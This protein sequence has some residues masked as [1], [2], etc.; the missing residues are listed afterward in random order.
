MPSIRPTC[1]RA[2]RRL[3]T[4]LFVA[5]LAVS[6]L[7]NR[8]PAG[9]AAG[10]KS[11]AA[12][13]G[14]RSG[15]APAPAAERE[16]VNKLYGQMPLQ[17]E[18][19][20]GQADARFDFLSRGDDY[21]VLLSPTEAVLSLKSEETLHGSEPSARS[22]T[23]KLVGAKHTPTAVREEEL[24]GCVNYFVGRNP[25]RRL[26]HVPTYSRV[27]Y[28]GIY[29]G[30]DVVYYGRRRALEYDFAVAPRAEVAAINLEFGGADRVEVAP[31][32]DLLISAGAGE[33]RMR[34][35]S[36]Y[37]ESGGRRL[38]VAG[39][40]VLTGE[41]TVGFKVGAYDHDRPLVIDPV[42]G[43]STFLGG[44]N[45]DSGN[46]IQVDAAGNAYI[47]GSTTSPDFPVTPNAA[48][49]SFN[50]GSNFEVFVTKLNPSGTAPV[51][52]TYLGG[53][54]FDAATGLA[55]DADGNVYV[56]GVT[57]SNDF[58]PTPGAVQRTL[59]HQDAFV[60]KLSAAGDAIIYSTYLGG[61]GVEERASIAVAAARDIY[62]A[63]YTYSTDFPVTTNA[64]RTTANPY[65][66]QDFLNA[67]DGFVAK[68]HP[69]G[70]GAADLVY[71]T[72]LG[73]NLGDTL[74][75]L[76]LDAA[77]FLYVVGATQSTNFPTT[78]DAVQPNPSQS[79]N[80]TARDN[81]SDGFVVKMDLRASGAA[82]LVYS[83]YV[84]GRGNDGCN[85]IAL[86]KGGEIYVAGTTRSPDFPTSR[87]ALQSS[88]SGGSD[89][90][91]MKLNLARSGP[92]AL[93]YSTYLGGEADDAAAGI[94]VDRAGNAYLTG[95]TRSTSLPVTVG[96][97][98]PSIGGVSDVFSAPGGDAFV[99]KL[100]AAGTALVYFSYLGGSGG[101]SGSAV[102]LDQKG[103]AYLT[104]L[105]FSTNFPL[106][107]N[108]FRPA[109]GGSFDAFV[110]RVDNPSSFAA[111]SA[112][113]PPSAA[114]ALA[115]APLSA[116]PNPVDDAQKFVRQQYLDFLN[117]EP[118]AAGLAFWTDGITS[119]GSD[120][121][122]V[123]VKRVNVSAAFFLSI[124]FQETGYLVERFYRASF[125]RAP[126]LTEF[127]PDTRAIRE[128]V[129]VN[130][131][132]WDQQLE[133]NKRSFAD[134]WVRRADFRTQ[135]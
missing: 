40:Y 73:G 105:T 94:A 59:N 118:D 125:A 45:G 132:G 127:A 98:Q 3:L 10:G 2:S 128:G 113:S 6:V 109:H 103:N 61:G 134:S 20:Q 79:T 28:K 129:I 130:Q 95:S 24:P 56:A 7:P 85:A 36:L 115:P 30:V 34:Q 120:A 112:A 16:R 67:T 19:N 117:R 51:F 65:A 22:L 32:G 15:V 99:A 135:E 92:A 76:A 39:G 131:P 33:V 27:G 77:G 74:N 37:Q 78:A 13:D 110:A 35:P 121:D 25:A 12:S 49:K 17:F 41:R 23:M 100:N 108:A 66:G 91:V 82:G 133:S 93:T 48:Q 87:D 44:V 53:G 5:S 83:T 46:G 8:M 69:A 50:S 64:Y 72:Y 97:F 126:R 68:I 26:T 102:A 21:T 29:A 75:A 18:A 114:E 81:E 62:L 86:G 71:S 84:A 60:T 31:D 43:Y 123:S 96:A 124:E 47:T 104:G 116:L 57:A 1:R 58:P 101:D 111:A 122:C 42:L 14:Q 70:A 54:D 52:S 107:A 106:S 89:A 63:G 55:L 88:P 80:I 11:I 38:A 90:F 9:L 4:A 119:C